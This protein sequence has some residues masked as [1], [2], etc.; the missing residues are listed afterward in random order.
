MCRANQ[1][2]KPNRVVI[3]LVLCLCT[4][5]L[6][7][8]AIV[9]ETS[10]TE[11]ILTVTDRMEER[12]KLSSNTLSLPLCS[13][14]ITAKHRGKGYLEITHTPLYDGTRMVAYTLYCDI[15]SESL[16]VI[17]SYKGN[18]SVPLTIPLSRVT[19]LLDRTLLGD[20][21][22]YRSNIFLH[23]RLEL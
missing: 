9:L 2:T 17:I 7:S 10:Q 4:C 14:V 21:S 22:S 15:R 5:S 3:L 8:G 1:A 6:I 23:L 13:L 12:D 11:M 18:P 20:R 19:A 16:P